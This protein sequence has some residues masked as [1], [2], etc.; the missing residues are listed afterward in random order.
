MF[1]EQMEV[2]FVWEHRRDYLVYWISEENKDAPEGEKIN[3]LE[4]DEVWRVYELGVRYRTLMERKAGLVDVWRRLSPRLAG[5]EAEEEAEDSDGMDIEDEEGGD[6]KKEKK[7]DPRRVYFESQVIS[8]GGTAE[9]SVEGVV[10]GME[11]LASRYAREVK[12]MREEEAE[13]QVEG[14]ERVYKKHSAESGLDVLRQSR[15]SR[16]VKVSS[17][18][19]F[20]LLKLS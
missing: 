17:F 10:D 19:F 11:W 3:L 16:F 1:T 20:Y 13:M 15:L 12:E 2:P 18:P 4:R 6:G 9:E 14:R 7:R 8:S 5:Q